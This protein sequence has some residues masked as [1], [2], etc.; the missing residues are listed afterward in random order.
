[1]VL[2]FILNPHPGVLFMTPSLHFVRAVL[3]LAALAPVTAAQQT[4]PYT[5]GPVWDLGFIRVNPG[6]E[7]DYL[8]NLRANWKRIGDEAKRQG[9]VLSYKV[10]STP[11]ANRDDWDLL[12]MVEYKNMAALD[13]LRQKYEPIMAKLI[14]PQTER[15]SRAAQRNEIREIIGGKLGRELILRDSTVQQAARP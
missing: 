13:G 3:L 6:M 5:E 7:D 8:N 11:A 2:P 10:I 9:L 4:A 14:G 15:R 1:M 12:L